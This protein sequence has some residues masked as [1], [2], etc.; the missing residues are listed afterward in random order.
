M[1]EIWEKVKQAYIYSFPLMLMDATMSVSTQRA[2]TNDPDKTAANR[3]MHAKE[4]ANASFRQ[5]VTPNVDTL[6]SQIFLDLSQ[7]ALVLHKPAVS[8]YVMFQIMDAWSDTVAVL[9]TGGDTDDE[10][11][12]LLTG[13]GY[14]GEIP[15]GMTRVQIPTCMGWLL[16]RV[17]CYGPEDLDN[18][19]RIQEE[20]DVR[21]LA[22]W[23]AGDE[24]PRESN[25][26]K[27]GGAPIRMV[28]SMGPEEYF[29]RVNKLMLD[30]PPYPEDE[31]LLQELS[32]LGVG[33]GL[34]FDPLILGKDAAENWKNMVGGLAG[35]LV[36]KNERFLV[37]N[38]SFRFFGAP[39]SRFQREYEYRCL[40]AIGGF[41]ANP[42]DVAVYMK[43][44]TDDTGASLNGRN[45]Y[46]MHIEPGQM[47]PCKEKG[48]WSITAY[49]DDDFLIGNPID[50][51]A[52]SDR[53][54]LE[55]NEDG[56]VDLYLQ[57]DEPKEHRSNWLPVS[58]EGFH[59]FLRIYRPEE[60]VLEGR[61]AAPSITVR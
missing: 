50:R 28:F 41:G 58:E 9:G 5:V 30:N 32:P 49:S 39:I 38:R 35:E 29:G 6:Y 16:G 59:L 18:I 27:Q 26:P 3:W 7:D 37:K 61:W 19:Y 2:E 45:R 31:Q 55:K 51:Y 24:L 42:V 12:Y 34:H 44:G 43:S 23:K 22:V 17:I 10:R 56:S 1:N 13:P 60:P 21:P 33:P 53:T 25:A 15:S 40:V 14:C 11:T 52:V 36:A 4:L 48:F 8:R 46:V 57:K 20:M 54:A 47:P